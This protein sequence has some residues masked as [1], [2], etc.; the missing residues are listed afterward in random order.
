M[1]GEHVNANTDN[2]VG[3]KVDRDQIVDRI[4]E[5]ALEPTSLDDFID[6]WHD[7]DLGSHFFEPEQTGNSD[8][9]YKAHLERAQAILQR[10]EIASRDLSDQLLPY[11]NLAAFIVG[12]SLCIEAANPG[13][14]AS[15]RINAGDA[16]DQ[17]HLPHELRAALSQATRDVL[18][19]T[20][21]AEKLLK[22]DQDSKG[23][24]LLFRVVR[25]ATFYEDDPAVLVVSTQFFW[26]ERTGALLGGVFHLTKAEQSVVRLLVEGHDTK[27]IAVSRGTSEGTARGQI[28]SIISKMN[29]RSQT[30][31]VRLVMSLGEFPKG[32]AGQETVEVTAPSLSNNWIEAEVW[33]PFKSVTVSDGRTLTYHDMGPS[34]GNP[35]LYSHTGSCLARWSASMIQLAYERN[36]RVICPIRAGYGHSDSL[37][38]SA[39]PIAEA[40]KDTL[41]LLKSL[42][43][44]RL[45][46]V[47]HGTDL[48]IA[49]HL[50]AH[51]P[52]LISEMIGLGTFPPLPGNHGTACPGRWQRF[53]V[54]TARNA[55]HLVFFASKAVMAMAKRIGPDAMLRQLCKE[56]PSDL[57]LLENE[58]MRQILAAN[59][60]LMAGKS[61]NAAG[62]FAME[63]IEFQKDW[64]DQM[65]ALRQIP[66]QVFLAEE[67][68]TLDLSLLPDLKAVYPWIVFEIFE[69]AGLSMLFQKSGK[70]VP[71]IAEAAKSGARS[72]KYK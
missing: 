16:L 31:I 68:P 24:A 14:K 1:L 11:E 22:A 26:R 32:S 41:C 30:D 21:S 55:P 43:I 27:S 67:D 29:V 70:L 20:G 49:A 52:E 19:P 65:M 17:I 69:N 42:G 25:L 18:R 62:A 9:S 6:F 44:Q 51:H 61:T 63:Y 50:V 36:L 2:R 33:K 37:E 12:S 8:D 66:M 56:Q 45:P 58:E 57:A 39:D 53:F 13:A 72:C 47:V 3:A 40:S 28:K 34:T 64:S 60:S 46:Y 10:G 15:F 23:G 4:Y 48:P 59:I 38:A 71:I 7:Y 5:I 35:V 54:T